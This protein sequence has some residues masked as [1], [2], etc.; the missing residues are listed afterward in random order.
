MPKPRVI[1]VGAGPGRADLVTVRG[2]EWIDKADVIYYDRLLDPA[3]LRWAKRSCRK[4]FV[5]KERGRHAV[6]QDQVIR[7]MIADAR[8]GH[9]VVRLKGGD[10]FV[11]GRGGEEALALVEAEVPFEVVPGV[12]AALGAAA[13]AGV[14]LTHRDISSSVVFMTGQGASGKPDTPTVVVYM[15]AENLAQVVAGIIESGRSGDTPALAVQWATWKEQKSV[16]ST[17]EEIAVAVREAKFGSPMLLVVGEV[18][19]FHERL[20]WYERK[21]VP[22]RVRSR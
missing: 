1:L 8:E 11:F 5:G 13:Y 3:M 21:T 15:P 7:R 9:C 17:L 4:I 6:P 14:P 18:A 20:N 10:P 22:G 19:R 16:L 12:T 2:R